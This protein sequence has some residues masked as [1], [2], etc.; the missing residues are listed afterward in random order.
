MIYRNTNNDFIVKDPKSGLYL[1]FVGWVIV[2][3]PT[4]HEAILDIEHYNM[5][6]E[7]HRRK[8]KQ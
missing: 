7:A 8:R 5:E 4:L 6:S 1:A 2:S 3:R